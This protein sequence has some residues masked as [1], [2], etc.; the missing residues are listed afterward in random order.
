MLIRTT[1]PECYKEHHLSDEVEGQSVR[2]KE[3]GHFFVV[4]MSCSWGSAFASAIT[5][6]E[7]AM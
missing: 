4:A 1:C 5:D 3:C 6:G 7:K 2:C